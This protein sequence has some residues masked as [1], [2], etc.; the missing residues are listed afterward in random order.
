MRCPT[1]RGDLG[2]ARGEVAGASYMIVAVVKPL[3]GC[4][5]PTFGLRSVM[6]AVSIQRMWLEGTLVLAGEVFWGLPLPLGRSSL[7][8]FEQ[9][10]IK[11][12]VPTT[13]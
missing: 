9:I 8:G 6:P 2:E 11:G 3:L 13:K 10:G 12:V 1:S 7:L 5:F 4:A